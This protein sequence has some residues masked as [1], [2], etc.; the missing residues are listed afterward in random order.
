[1]GAHRYCAICQEPTPS[2]IQRASAPAVGLGGEALPLDLGWADGA[3]LDLCPGCAQVLSAPVMLAD[4]AAAFAKAIALNR[5]K[6]STALSGSGGA[7]AE[8]A[9]LLH[10]AL[11]LGLLQ[12]VAE[13]EA[14]SP[15]TPDHSAPGQL[16]LFTSRAAKLAKVEG[17]I[18]EGRLAE[19]TE[20][21]AVLAAA[22]DMP[23]ARALARCLPQLVSRLDALRLEPEALAEAMEQPSALYDPSQLTR[24]LVDA[25]T[26]HLSRCVAEAAGR[27]DFL[28]VR[29]QPT[30]WYWLQGHR[31]EQARAC[32]EKASAQGV[33]VGR[34]LSLLGD[35]AFRE[36]R[37]LAA[38]EFYRRAFCE[39]PG[40]VDAEVLADPGVRALVDD[41]RELELSPPEVWVPL[42]GWAA[43]LFSLP[44]EPQG[45]AAARDFHAALLEARLR[46]D[47][48]ARRRMKN[49]APLL[50]ERLRDGGRL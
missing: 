14:A 29:G 22:Y 50:F 11:R 33:L 31:P 36:G 48:E 21:A 25:L 45:Q 20:R 8:R 24:P 18:A 17:A 27:R 46:G 35:L 12:L 38:R 40:G 43:N 7:L 4:D 26:G 1:M 13:L 3:V 2:L 34:A 30:G 39:D 23:E 16:D 9:R 47:I 19:A 49:L 5:R 15:Q 42:A 32:L 28:L 10:R 44:S 41:A 6:E 37:A